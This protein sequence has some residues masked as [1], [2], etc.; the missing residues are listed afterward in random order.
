MGNA[1]KRIG[2]AVLGMSLLASSVGAAEIQPHRAIYT[3]KLEQSKDG[4]GVA[5]AGGQMM[6]EWADACDGWVVEQ[7]YQMQLYYSEAEAQDL[8]YSFVTWEAKDGSRYRFDV[9]RWMDGSLDEE[10]KGAAD[11]KSGGTGQASF[12]LPEKATFDLPGKT[13][14]PSIHTIAVI[15]AALKGEAFFAS[16]V[17]DGSVPEGAADVTAAI[18][19]PQSPTAEAENPLLRQRWWPVR[20]AFFT[21]DGDAGQAGESQPDFEIGMLLQENGIA[22]SLTVDYGSFAVKATLKSLEALPRQKC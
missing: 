4:S 8:S 7:R 18:G 13:L 1:V 3:L 2:A 11:M 5:G 21:K 15:E 19:Q 22:R 9:K 17:F 16:P 12:S 14:F 10:L 6:F 20:I